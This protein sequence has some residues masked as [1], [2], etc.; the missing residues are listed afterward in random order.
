MMD[1]RKLLREIHR[2]EQELGAAREAEAANR[3][4]SVLPVACIALDGRVL[5]ATSEGRRAL[6]AVSDPALPRPLQHVDP[7]LLQRLRR[8][9]PSVEKT[10]QTPVF[11]RD[12]VASHYTAVVRPTELAGQEAL[13]VFFLAEGEAYADVMDDLRPG[14][15]LRAGQALRT[16]EP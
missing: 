16:P 1:Q 4:L 6:E 8:A 3:V 5:L 15:L 14:I 13:V 9:A 12:G 2:L 11:H 7:M 10:G